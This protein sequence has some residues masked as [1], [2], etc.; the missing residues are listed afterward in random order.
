MKKVL[1]L[2]AAALAV[3][4]LAQEKE[5]PDYGDFTVDAQVRAL[6]EYRGGLGT[7]DGKGTASK[8]FVSDRVRLSLGW[9]R[10]NLSMKI[11]AQHSGLWQGASQKNTAGKITLYEAWARMAFG[12]G[13]FGQAGRQVLSYDDERLLGEHD[14]APMGSTHDALR[15]GWENTRHKI[16][17]IASFNQV[18]D[19]TNVLY[20]DANTPVVKPYKNMQALWYHFGRSEGPFQLSALFLN[21]GVSDTKADSIRYMQ[22]FGLYASFEKRKFL[23]NASFYYQTGRDRTGADVSAYMASANIGLKFSPKWKVTLGDDFLSGSDGLSATNHTFNILYGSHH[24]FY[25]A[26][27]LLGYGAI[28]TYGLNDLNLEAQFTPNKKFDVSLACHWFATPNPI[29]D[30]LKNHSGYYIYSVYRLDSESQKLIRNYY[31]RE[32]RFMQIIGT[33]VDLQASYRPWDF[34]TIQAGFSVLAGTETIQLLTGSDASKVQ[35]WAWVSLDIN[36]TIFSTRHRR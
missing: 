26:M 15:L 18:A 31:A 17:A 14:W 11:A 24:K 34:F 10:K 5:A 36:P 7:T 4:A 21:Q 23:A 25:G 32:H 2:L 13:F 28:P 22:T 9:E 19:L 8:L 6:G 16:H 3:A 1:T 12:K 20:A 29:K 30:Y 33:E 35:K 27:D